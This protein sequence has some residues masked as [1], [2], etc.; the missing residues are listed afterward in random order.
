MAIQR[1]SAEQAANLLAN[2]A[3]TTGDDLVEIAT[4]ILAEL[5]LQSSSAGERD[6]YPNASD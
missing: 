3:A 5:R 2:A 1:C 4:R 6:T